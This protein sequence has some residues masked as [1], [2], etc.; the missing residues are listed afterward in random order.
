MKELDKA[1]M[2]RRSDLSVHSM[3]DLPMEVAE[4]LPLVGCSRREDPRDVLVLPEGAKEMDFSKPIGTS[5][6]RREPAAAGSCFRKPGLRVS[7]GICKPG[8]GSWTK[9]S[10]ERSCWQLPG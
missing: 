3:K 7:G 9:V 4:E 8:C 10:S 2:D 6:L 1:L 5:S